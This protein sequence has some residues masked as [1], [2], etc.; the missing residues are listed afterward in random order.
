[1]GV[2]RGVPKVCLYALFAAVL[3]LGVAILGLRYWLLPNIDRYR[4]QIAS[5]VSEA[6][7]T[8]V[9]IGA[10]RAGW[11]GLRP[12]LELDG[13]QV[14]DH[15][16]EPA[17]ELVKVGATLSWRSL[18]AGALRLSALE[19][20]QPSVEIKR[21]KDGRFSVAGIPLDGEQQGG[22]LSGLLLQT[23]SVTVDGALLSWEDQ[24]HGAPPLMLDRVSL[25]LENRGARHRFGLTGNPP[26]HLAGRVDVRGDVRSDVRYG[27]RG[28]GLAHSQ[29]WIQNWVGTLYAELPYADAGAW[30][31]YFTLPPAVIDGR[32][33]ARLWLDFHDRQVQS[34]LADVKL[35]D[36]MVRLK[37]HLP[38]LDLA[39]LEGRIRYRAIGE[40]FEVTTEKL[41]LA[42]R[43]ETV[44][45]TAPETNPEVDPQMPPAIRIGSTDLLLRN[46]PAQAGQPDMPGK[47][48][49]PG[50]AAHGELRVNQMELA[51]WASLTDYLPLDPAMKQQIAGFFPSGRISDLAYQWTGEASAPANYALSGKIDRGE[52]KA[53]EAYPGVSGLAGSFEASEQGGAVAIRALSRLDLPK[54]FDAPLDLDHFTMKAKWRRD[55]A[56]TKITFDDARFSNPHLAGM[57]SGSYRAIP[58]RRGVIDMRG[59]LSRFEGARIARYLPHVLA[60]KTRTWLNRA[61]VQATVDDATL[62]L[63]GDLQDFPFTNDR[64]GQFLLGIRL[65]DGVLDY[66]EAWPRIEHIR[67]IV[68]VHGYGVEVKASEGSILGARISNVVAAIGDEKV[69]EPILEVTGEA[70][71]PFAEKLRFINLSPV[72][73]MVGTLTEGLAGSGNGKLALK[74]AIPLHDTRLTQVDGDYLFDNASFDLGANGPPVT[75]INGHLLFSQ[76][77]VR[78]QGITG[79]VLG[80]PIKADVATMAEGEVA[81]DARGTASMDAIRAFSEQPLLKYVSGS[82]DWQG[83][84]RLRKGGAALTLSSPMTGVAIDLPAPLGKAA[85]LEMPLDLERKSSGASMEQ[86]SAS[87]GGVVF[88]ELERGR[89]AGREGW[90]FKR[91]TVSFGKPAVLP[92]QQGLWFAGTLAT[93]DTR[94]WREVLKRQNEASG[95]AGNPG[96]VLAGVDLSFGVID[97]FDH[98]FARLHLLAKGEADNWQGSISGPEV[99]GTFTWRPA[100]KGR[101][102]AR[103]ARLTIPDPQSAAAAVPAPAAPAPGQLDSDFPA[104]DIIADEIHIRGKDFG[105]VELQAEQQGGD[106]RIERLVATKA[107]ATLEASGLWSRGVKPQTALKL[108]LSAADPGRLLAEFGYPDRVK[109]GQA[110]L[111]GDLSWPG[112]PYEMLPANLSGSLR[113]EAKAGQFLKADPGA[114]RL[115][116][117]LSLQ[118]LPRRVGLDFRDVFSE[119]FAFD[120]IRGDVRIQQGVMHTEGFAIVGP[121]AKVEMTGEV[122]LVHETQQLSV[123]VMPTLG[124]GISLATGL[125][126]GPVVGLTAFLVQR[127]FKDPISR[128][129]A[130]EYSV[131]GTWDNPNVVKVAR[132]SVEDVIKHE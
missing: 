120:S 38:K 54:V 118:A 126:G 122:N 49:K 41:S 87:L 5:R 106:W 102:Y 121:A 30:R 64:N 124:E 3:L 71:G 78:G 98:T 70:S 47:T 52:A 109:R 73:N 86:I 127:A 35:A 72:K 19:I 112:A 11:E 33:A 7:G 101:V 66:A 46:E 50:K 9:T 97:V 68:T 62:R 32:G 76:A 103:F 84:M 61:I 15:D 57:A 94:A 13:V 77:G 2:L 83:S 39:S 40:G 36:A 123:K 53:V 107:D 58:G 105:R 93:L 99:N 20:V 85:G 16:G 116:G 10:I 56:A 100:G 65:A 25:R 80:G 74:L 79:K 104:L 21:D 4:D 128:A 14:F 92:D 8:R 67:A 75:G 12:H 89:A 24:L 29:D 82:A 42:S 18:P 110:D 22:G 132:K 81:I 6:T 23:R 114:G 130:Y 125:L 59:R 26:D 34:L 117:L 45:K 44:P 119:G 91:G 28:E 37:E 90:L 17:L 31:R 63:T 27:A 129:V 108:T 111:S 55:G 43:A 51:A 115:L 88:A 69:A 95:T 131:S 1:M 96:T 113:L 60:A 48:D